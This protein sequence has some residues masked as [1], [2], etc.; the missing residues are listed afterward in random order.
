MVGS[1]ATG[2]RAGVDATDNARCV[3]A[4]EGGFV[5]AVAARDGLTSCT[6]FFLDRPGP[7][8][9]AEEELAFS[10]GLTGDDSLE[11]DGEL[12]ADAARFGRVFFVVV[13][14]EVDESRGLCVVDR[15]SISDGKVIGLAI[16]WVA[17]VN[18]EVEGWSSIATTGRGCRG[19]EDGERR[20]Y[21]GSLEV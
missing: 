1:D 12:V 20:S 9:L 11:G 14:D 18:I 2:C 21:E 3:A 5:P 4:A 19:Y 16:S 17:A 15:W 8:D 10:G 7:V 13:T 6:L